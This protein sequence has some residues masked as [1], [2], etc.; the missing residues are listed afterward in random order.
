M[1]ADNRVQQQIIGAVAAAA[2]PDAP[3]EA[4]AMGQRQRERHISVTLHG[5]HSK[6]AS[7]RRPIT[8]QRSGLVWKGCQA[9]SVSLCFRDL[10]FQAE[11]EG[12]HFAALGFGHFERVERD[13]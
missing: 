5:G 12:N 11:R 9:T 10:C 1:V 2:R 6:G 7:Q 13:R 4:L 3:T 8:T